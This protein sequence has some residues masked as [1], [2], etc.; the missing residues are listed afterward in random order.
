[1]GIALHADIAPESPLSGLFGWMLA[2]IGQQIG[3]PVPEG[4]SSNLTAALVR[5]LEGLGGEVRCN[6]PIEH[7][8][9]RNQ[10]AVAVRL[11]DG[12]EVDAGKAVIADVD[13]P[14]LYLDL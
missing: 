11:Q 10:R 2:C 7:V 9:I 6:S 12:T 1:A 4:G 3:W 8:I 14:R 5:R 13:A